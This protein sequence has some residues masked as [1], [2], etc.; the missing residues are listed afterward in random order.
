[1]TVTSL[2]DGT[3]LTVTWDVP[4]N[5]GPDITGYRL[6]CTGH[7]V[8]DNQC[9]TD[10]ATT[11]V[12]NGVGTHN[13]TELT[14]DK[15]YRV[16]VRADNDEG[17][18][19]W[20]SFITQSTNKENNALPTFGS[21]P[22]QLYVAENASSA[23]QPVTIDSDGMEVVA[24][25]TTISDGEDDSLTYRLDGPGAGRF[26]INRDGQITTISKLNHEDQE[27]NP[28]GNRCSY[29]MRVKVSDPNG[30]SD[31]RS[32]T[33]D[34]TDAVE[35][36][37]APAAPRVTATAG[38]GWSLEVTWNE[39]RNTGPTITAY[40]VRYRKSGDSKWEEWSHT[41]T[42]RSTKITTI[43]GRGK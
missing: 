37:D 19:A 14:A 7:E 3:T 12:S 10:I 36:P 27:C 6:E 30:G 38:S 24:L 26:D 22:T 1:M 25:G 34:V 23:R 15:S 39:P 42:S 31:F 32:L 43:R 8:P 21:T 9:P 18:G 11:A 29:K 4:D 33:I 16:R 13:I 2:V 28:S 17:E 20:S 5:T 41:G 40:Q 35:P